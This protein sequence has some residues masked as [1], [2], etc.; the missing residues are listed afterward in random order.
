MKSHSPS[1]EELADI[2]SYSSL[3]MDSMDMDGQTYPTSLFSYPTSGSTIE[4]YNYH[5]VTANPP[6]DCTTVTAT[7]KALMV[8]NMETNWKTR[9]PKT[10]TSRHFVEWLYEVFSN[11]SLS[12][13][14]LTDFNLMDNVDGES[15]SQ[16]TKADFQNRFPH[17]EIIYDCFKKVL[18]DFNPINDPTNVY[19]YSNLMQY[20]YQY[21]NNWDS[22]SN[23][24]VN[25]ASGIIDITNS[26]LDQHNGVHLSSQHLQNHAYDN[27]FL[28]P[29]NHSSGGSFKSE[30][31]SE[32]ESNQSF[33]YMNPYALDNVLASG[34][35]G[36]SEKRRRGRPPQIKEK[37]KNKNGQ[38]SSRLWEFIRDLLL[39]P[40]TCPSLLKW[41]NAEEGVFRFVQSDQV[42][43]LWGKR[44]CNP[45]M[46]YEKL[47]RAM[48]YYYKNKVFQ[49]VT[50]RRLVYKFGPTATGWRPTELPTP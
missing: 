17:G 5:P 24:P 27:P 9:H 50:G 49:S 38:R 29:N 48:R 12:Y 19:T 21:D 7:N 1:H 25:N 14:T 23:N 4:T 41:E 16:M 11:R 34:D 36:E 15:L 43:K 2:G 39:D 40:K 18:S 13:E 33:S 47:S 44:K 30:V 20:P 35:N 46:T 6:S 28:L 31:D 45:R 26:K 32:G 42:A 3:P 37:R 22:I 10:W 8:T